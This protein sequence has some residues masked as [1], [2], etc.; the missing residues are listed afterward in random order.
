MVGGGPVGSGIGRG[1]V[2]CGD[3]MITVSV[4]CGVTGVIVVTGV[5]DDDGELPEPS[6]GLPW[7]KVPQL[8]LG[9]KDLAA[10][11]TIWPLVTNSQGRKYGLF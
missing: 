7:E 11:L 6:L 3:G 1:A 5:E 4:G 10:I 2:G 9:K 8:E